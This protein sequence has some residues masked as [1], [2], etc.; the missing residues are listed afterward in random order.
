MTDHRPERLN[1]TCQAEGCE[2][3]ASVH[4]KAIPL[5]TPH[6][7]E[8]LEQRLQAPVD[9]RAGQLEPELNRHV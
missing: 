8:R 7:Q 6:Y 1:E 5:C 2:R 4:W 9:T 3:P